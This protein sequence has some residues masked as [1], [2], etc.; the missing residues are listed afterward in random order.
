MELGKFNSKLY[1]LEE[2]VVNPK[3]Y[4]HAPL[5]NE[6][7]AIQWIL[8]E[9]GIH[10]YN[11]AQDILSKNFI[12]QLP[13][14]LVKDGK[15]I[16]W[17]GNRR[18]A[19]L[20]VV[21]TPSL[22]F[23]S[24]LRKKFQQLSEAFE[25]ADDLVIEC[26]WTEDRDQADACVGNLHTTGRKGI[27]RK[28]WGRDEQDR[29]N[30]SRK[31]VR[32]VRDWLASSGLELPTNSYEAFSRLC[33][34][35]YLEKLGLGVDQDGDLI[36]RHIDEDKVFQLWEQIVAE[37]A[38]GTVNVINPLSD[39]QRK[40]SYI[41]QKAEFLGQD[42][43]DHRKVPINKVPKT[44]YKSKGKKEVLQKNFNRSTLIPNKKL[45]YLKPELPDK[46]HQVV[47]ELK[48][49]NVYY[50]L[51]SS[52]ILFRCLL[53][54]CIGVYAKNH[55]NEERVTSGK[56]RE[57]M[58]A[59]VNLE[60]AEN[61]KLCTALN[62]AINSEHSLLSIHTFNEVVHNEYLWASSDQLKIAWDTYEPLICRIIAP[63]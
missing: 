63:D 46:L 34:K 39:P 23:D 36:Y 9:E 3:N 35:E 53:E 7:E 28:S 56:L 27:G 10:T 15:N 42:R 18:V 50:N 60:F 13:L 41:S 57:R 24:T 51:I 12:E 55:P 52:A 48:H 33:T 59:M 40:Q 16:V 19:G 14:I 30:N 47:K 17:E 26:S 11:L 37:I 22:C 58:T 25:V 1:S 21:V 43:T 20:K 49:L 61:K 62:K 6:A 29:F 32:Q 45:Q 2:L 8:K 5:P 38:T 4:R 44:S 31:P 54:L